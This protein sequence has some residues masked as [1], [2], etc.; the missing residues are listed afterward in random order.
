MMAKAL[1]TSDVLQR[2]LD[3]IARSLEHEPLELDLTNHRLRFADAL[4]RC[5]RGNHYEVLEVDPGAGEPEV[6]AA[7]EAV[8][9]MVHP[10]HSERLGL[11]GRQG[12]TEVVFERAT[13]AYLV[14]SDPH[15]RS[16]YDREEGVEVRRSPAQRAKEARSV[17]RD[18]YGRAQGLVEREDFH[19]ALELLQQA[20]RADPEAADCWA[21]LGRCRAQNPKWLHMAA[22]NLRRAI[23]LRPDSAELRQELA[24]VEEGRGNGEEAAR[25]YRE[26]LE[27]APGNTLAQEGLERLEGGASEKSRRRWWGW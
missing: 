22:D 23:Q 17:A 6:H 13:E 18:L 27:R 5:S 21:L 2:F 19:Y 15:R 26:V 20:V 8:A 9:R 7:Y 14:L 3:R 11:A 10:S 24:R 12:V 4:G 16:R 25:L 1:A